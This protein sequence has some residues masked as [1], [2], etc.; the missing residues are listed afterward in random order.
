MAVLLS[1]LYSISTVRCKLF[2]SVLAQHGVSE[3]V[4]SLKQAPTS[5]IPSLIPQSIRWHPCLLLPNLATH[6][7]SLNARCERPLL[8]DGSKRRSLYK[9]LLILHNKFE[10]TL[11]RHRLLLS[12][13]NSCSVNSWDFK[14]ISL[15]WG[16]ECWK[17]GSWPTCLV[18]SHLQRD[19]G[20]WS[21]TGTTRY[22]DDPLRPQ[23]AQ[24]DGTD[25]KCD[26]NGPEK[27]ILVPQ[28]TDDPNDPLV[29]SRWNS[30]Y[31]CKLIFRAVELATMETGSYHFH[32]LDDL[33][34]H[35]GPGT[36]SCGEYFDAFIVFWK[37]VYGYGAPDRL[38]PAWSW[39]RWNFGMNNLILR[40]FFI[41]ENRFYE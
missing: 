1:S 25:L 39:N 31:C 4:L 26:T 19:D 3:F 24:A 14:I 37:N 35:Y 13:V 8:T 20:F 40:N 36:Y 17:T 2:V 29:S 34:F 38:F 16:L 30:K 21:P 27:I 11:S 22:Y 15:S 5:R 7:K 23:M 9:G 18:C 6:P 41:R 32:P 12:F 10:I 28:P 33:Y